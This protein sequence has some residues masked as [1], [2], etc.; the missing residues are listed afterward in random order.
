MTPTEIETSARLQY[1]AVGDSFWSTAEI[2]NLMWQACIELAAVTKN[3][4]RVYTTSTVAAQQE[5]SYPTNTISIKR[6]TYEGK[7]LQPITMRE[8]DA[9]TGLNQATTDQGTPQ[10]YFIWNKTIYLRPIPSAVGTL[11]IF[12]INTPQQITA[13][14]TLEIPEELHM[15]IVD[16]ILG[17]MAA[18]DR[19]ID[20]SQYYMN[21]WKEHKLEAIKWHKRN[22]RG[23]SF[24]SVQDEEQL[25]GSY[26]GLI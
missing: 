6:I 15:S 11:K 7:K 17:R 25:N 24:A 8:D 19:Q 5:Y 3:V 13:T 23:D 14:S 20:I 1:N 10:Y 16:Y 21:L 22:K 18:K 2:L 12:S 26:L 9:I 4:E